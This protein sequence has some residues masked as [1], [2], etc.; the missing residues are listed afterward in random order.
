MRELLLVDGYNVINSWPEL[1][2][3]RDNL[4]DA[5]DKLS[6]VMAEYGEYHKYDVIIVFD[7]LF[8]A[9][10]EHKDRVNCHLDII[11]TGKGE[12]ADSCIERLTYEAV[13]DGRVVRVVTSDGAEQSV[14]L[15][16]GASRI[17]SLELRR[18]VRRLKKQL[19]RDY[20]GK[21]TLPVT[22]IEVGDRLDPET[23]A[24]LDTMR[25]GHMPHEKP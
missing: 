13:N 14:I 16:A 1:K 25:K 9:D 19:R 3:L 18:D 8:T 10:D 11:Y 22:R 15:G 23:A 4:G 6:D 20:T 24:R 2:P 5:R 17:P 21:V 12:T 7:A